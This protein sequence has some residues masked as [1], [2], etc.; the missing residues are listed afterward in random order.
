MSGP[1]A[2][3]RPDLYVV[4]RLLERLWREDAPMLKTRLQVAANVNYDVF[5][6]YLEWMTERG[7]VSVEGSPDGHARVALTAKGHEAYRKLV[8]WINE[9][10]RGNLPKM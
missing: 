7:L 2:P 3:T 6:R 8:Q 10:V 9:V 5:G 1:A 4:A